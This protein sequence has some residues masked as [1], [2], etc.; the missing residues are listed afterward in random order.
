MTAYAGWLVYYVI[1]LPVFMTHT[2]LV[3]YW[4]V[5]R[6]LSGLKIILFVVFFGLMMY[7]FSLCE[8]LITSNVL[9]ELFPGVFTENL[10]YRDPLNVMISG[11]GNLYI[12]LVFAAAKLIRSWFIADQREKQILKHSL[13]VERADANAGIQPEMLLF[14]IASIEQ[15]GPG[16]HEDVPSAI[17]QLSE[18]LNS[19]M[20]AHRQHA[21]RLNEELRNVRNLIRLY[22]VLFL[23]EMPEVKIEQRILPDSLFPAFML[24]SPLEILIRRYQWDAEDRLHVLIISR[25]SLE[26]SWDEK[27]PGRAHPDIPGMKAELD[28]LYPGRY[29]VSTATASGG[30]RLVIDEIT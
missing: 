6:F 20:R 13:L 8:T 22:S 29:R 7:F 11:I 3:M 9:T 10:N 26:I 2:Y 17:A 18:L 15:M 21:I 12:I 25:Q 24:F 28:R 23:K 14:S 1:T 16:R 30:Q 4:A 19:V 5:P 27:I